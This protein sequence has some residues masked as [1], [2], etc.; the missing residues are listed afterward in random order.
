MP[1]RAGEQPGRVAARQP[2]CHRHVACGTIIRL[3]PNSPPKDRRRSVVAN[4]WCV[5]P[6]GIYRLTDAAELLGVSRRTLE[7][8]VAAGDLTGRRVGRYSY[9]TG[10]SLLSYL[11]R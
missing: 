9:V 1:G 5:K 11:E 3:H 10:R 2:A 8:A 4:V 6:N 7:R